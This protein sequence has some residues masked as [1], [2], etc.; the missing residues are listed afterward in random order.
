MRGRVSKFGLER[1]V[2]LKQIRL[3][4]I[5]T[6]SIQLIFCIEFVKPYSSFLTK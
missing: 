6:T 5:Q 3:V 2:V 4:V 1:I